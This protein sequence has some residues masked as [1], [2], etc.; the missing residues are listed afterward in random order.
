[1]A[2]V[3]GLDLGPNSIGWALLE[4]DIEP[5][6]RW[7]HEVKGF[8]DTSAA[9]HPPIGVRVFE[10]GVPN[11]GDRK[12][13]SPAQKRRMARSVRRNHQRRSRR[14]R[15]TR[16]LLT[17]LGFLPPP[18]P[19]RDAVLALDPYE[20]RAKGL[21]EPLTRA[22]FA[23]AILHIAARRGFK[24]NRKTGAAKDDGVMLKAIGELEKEIKASGAR[25]L[26]EFLA[27]LRKRQLEE[28]PTIRIRARHT[29]REMY[30][31][32]FDR[33]VAEQRK[34]H[35][36]L[37]DAAIEQL[38]H[39]VF[40]QRPFE[41]DEA[42]RAAAPPR[43]NL[44]RAP[45]VKRCPLEPKER[46][47][48]KGLWVA[49]RFRL[50]KE[51]NNLRVSVNGQ[52]YRELT[53]EERKVVLEE[54]EANE[55]RKF[56]QL[57]KALQKRVSHGC[58]STFQ[59][60]LERGWRNKLDGNV[61]EAKLRK[62]FDKKHAVVP[63]AEMPEPA[64]EQL[65]LAL[66]EDEDDDLRAKLEE[67]G[68]TDEKLEGLLCWTPPDGYL[69]YSRKAI[70]KML[71]LLEERCPESQ[72]VQQCYPKS[73]GGAAM[74]RLPPFS[75]KETP[76]ELRNV[77]NPLVL[78]ALV[79]MRKVVN[80]I[81]R[82]H[83][84]PA[85]IVVELARE[86]K[87][88]KRE[89]EEYSKRTRVLQKEREAASEF[90]RGHGGT[91]S[92]A[93]ILRVRLWKEQ[94]G[95]CLYTG[96]PIPQSAV[97]GGGEFDIDHI[98]P[99]WQSLDDSYMNKVLVRRS[100]NAE[101]GDRTVIQWLGEGSQQYR[102]ILNRA[103]LWELPGPKVRRLQTKEV[104]AD[105]FSSRQ[106]NDTRYISVLA[107]R[108][109]ELLYPPKQR[110]G[111]PR[112]ATHPKAVSVCSGGFTAEL[113][114]LWG[115]EG[116]IPP[117]TDLD[118]APVV[119]PSETAG[120][121]SRADHR[122]HAVDAVV[123]GLTTPST[124]G[125]L[126]Q[127]RRALEK[128][129]ARDEV[130]LSAPW[131]ELRHDLQRHLVHVNVSHR[132]RKGLYDA[133]HE[134]TFRGAVRDGRGNV[135]EGRFTTRKALEDL[136]HKEIAAIRSKEVREIVE[137]RLRDLGWTQSAQL[138]KGWHE[139]LKHHNGLPIKKV[140]LVVGLKNTVT[141]G[142]R[143]HRHAKLGNN[144]H[145][146]FH[147]QE[148]GSVHPTVVSMLEATR[149]LRSGRRSAQEKKPAFTLARLESVLVGPPSDRRL[150]VV[151]KFSIVDGRIDLN[152]RDARDARKADTKPLKRIQSVKA[153]TALSP[154][155]VQVDQLGRI[156]PAGD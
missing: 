23:R 26:G 110:V 40:D 134:E 88:S 28:D 82:E 153:W 87:Q 149:L 112:L 129:A 113:R 92:P 53:D 123:V 124:L 138:P 85:R 17:D 126:S 65:R 75:S 29:K 60:N 83:G 43:A 96:D 111:D 27:G 98:L 78:R 152:L 11:L 156:W 13:K 54:L 41:V 136:S 128:G 42:R 18:G 57:G 38:R 147:V 68:L 15:E 70:E 67:A 135:V 74:D 154:S 118:G 59:F 64:K 150:A 30:A 6:E 48:P 86:L 7:D 100:A 33:L 90:I 24:S 73:S 16:R 5:G 32:E 122:H 21:D 80:A 37:T 77:T 35:P 4:A 101:K 151:Q 63:W 144:H 116:V 109:L 39:V 127:Y 91:P 137:R 55:S 97:L 51:V 121:K 108:Y 102:E 84:K 133:L 107:T 103:K 22:E 93:I 76:V 106:L 94:Q 58:D 14:R 69:G 104:D 139:G 72:A 148:D 115:L 8:L 89:R 1:M 95:R 45:S 31:K 142:D 52:P 49:Q 66:V 46:C 99:R 125:R 56:D 119:D 3:L 34:H 25:T 146:E 44:H 50:L 120:R 61:V 79:E 62:A 140:R 2:Y 131:P 19:G 20:A 47:C 155:K 9:G 105:Q 130:K 71:P 12:E 132:P 114:R 117:M 10:A 36:E 143:S 81:V 145:V 141:L